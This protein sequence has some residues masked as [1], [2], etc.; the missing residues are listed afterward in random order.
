ME[1]LTYPVLVGIVVPWLVALMTNDAMSST[2][3]RWVTIFITVAVSALVALGVALYYGAFNAE[4]IVKFIGVVFAVMQIVYSAFK[5]RGIDALR[6][7][8]NKLVLPEPATTEQ[9]SEGMDTLLGTI[10]PTVEAT[11]VVT[12]LATS[13]ITD[14]IV[15]ED[16]T[17]L[18]PFDSESFYNDRKTQD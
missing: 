7:K 12:P 3:K 2:K 8:T 4:E 6:A 10:A 18:V 9:I 16:P 15:E 14:K 5:E 17:D 11:T 1:N 13:V